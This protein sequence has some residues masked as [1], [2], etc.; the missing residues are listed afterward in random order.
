MVSAGLVPAQTVF[1]F[2]NLERGSAT[3]LVRID[4]VQKATRRRVAAQRLVYTVKTTIPHHAV[5]E[6][7]ATSI[8]RETDR[9]A[10]AV[11]R[12][13]GHTGSADGATTCGLVSPGTEGMGAPAG[14]PDACVRSG[15]PG[16]PAAPLRAVCGALQS[17][18]KKIGV[19]GGKSGQ[20]QTSRYAP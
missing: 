18:Q 8:P 9:V 17:T 14:R 1:S 16:G 10:P 4:A 19:R 20:F 7:Q 3:R 15:G 2:D 12:A 13:D 11:S 5:V 6:N